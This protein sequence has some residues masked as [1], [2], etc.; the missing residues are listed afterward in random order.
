MP[1]PGTCLAQEDNV[2]I[3]T[4][5]L[6]DVLLTLKESVEKLDS[7]NLQL[8]S[9]DETIRAQLSQLQSQLGRVKAQGEL[10]NKSVDKLRSP[11][12]GRAQQITR[13]EEEN[14][15]LDARLQHAQSSIQLIQQSLD[16]GF[17]EDQKLLLQLKG[18]SNDASSLPE[19]ESPRIAADARL[20][21][22]KLRLLKMIYESQQRQETLHA[23]ILE[24]QQ[25]TPLVPAAAAL[26]HQQQLNA[27]IKDLEGQ[28]AQY[29]PVKTGFGSAD[30]WDNDQLQQLGTELKVLERSYLQLKDL[31][32]K[33]GQKAR[34]FKMTVSQHVEGDK[35]QSSLDDLNRQGQ[36]LKADLEDFRSQMIE[37]DKRKTRLEEMVKQL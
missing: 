28:I 8:A 24:T 5:G 10:L 29:P 17:Q 20:Q 37:L 30:Q 9:Q 31:T 26:A 27:Q 18:L 3:A 1:L 36:G 15:Q 11:N 21:K 22:E 2:T 6:Q 7:D 32:G 4:T 12:P 34:G 35:L 14:S 19:V 23:S 25:K 13:L 33:M 16:S